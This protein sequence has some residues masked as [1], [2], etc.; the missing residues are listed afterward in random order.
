MPKGLTQDLKH[1][2]SITSGL[3]RKWKSDHSSQALWLAHYFCDQ[4]ASFLFL[5]APL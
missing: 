1:M 2:L 3:G 4:L 5:G